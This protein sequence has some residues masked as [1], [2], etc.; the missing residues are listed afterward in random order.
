M[1]VF[2]EIFAEDNYTP[3]CCET[4]EEYIMLTSQ[5]PYQDKELLEVRRFVVKLVL[6]SL[7]S[8]SNFS[9]KTKSC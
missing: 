9:I 4:R 2:N 7:C 6:R 3:I 8:P 1:E 5:F